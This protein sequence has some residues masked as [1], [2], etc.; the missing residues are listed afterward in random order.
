[1]KHLKGMSL[2]EILVVVS[3]FAVLGVITTRAVLLTLQGSKKSE[4]LVR[5]RENLN[6]ALG[7]VERQIRNA[8]SVTE[9]PNP[10]ANLIT[11]ADARG[12][13]STFSCVNIGSDDGYI[14]SASARLTSDTVNVTTCS[15]VCAVGSS[16]NPPSVTIT[17]EATDK[18]A[19]GIQ[20]SSVS[21]TTQIY[22]RNY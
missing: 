1:M 19:T 11:Y 7:T 9:C 8:D 12:D 15:F 6:F 10:D 13:A 21:T 3:I 22:L 4:S 16:L 17:M 2:L 5:V 18:S 14:A 20:G